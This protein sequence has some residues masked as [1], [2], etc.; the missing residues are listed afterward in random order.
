MFT[1]PIFAIAALLLPVSVVGSCLAQACYTISLTSESCE[2]RK[3]DE[4]QGVGHVFLKG[5]VADV[6]EVRCWPGT[7][8]E[9]EELEP[10]NDIGAQSLFA[11][12][13]TS[14]SACE[15][16]VDKTVR[17]FVPD[18]CCDTLPQKGDCKV[19]SAVLLTKTP[20]HI[21]AE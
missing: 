12:R 4:E 9:G 18:Q 3:T 16:F 6:T 5:A 21:Q 19:E 14:T 10:R 2:Y 11:F 7:P 8:Y 17:V 20:S 13:A 15:A 1:R